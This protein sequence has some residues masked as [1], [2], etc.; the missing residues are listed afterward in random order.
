MTEELYPVLTAGLSVT[1]AR[2]TFH[3]SSER[4][5]PEALALAAPAPARLSRRLLGALD[6]G[7]P[8]TALLGVLPAVMAT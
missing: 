5:K 2:W 8:A 1:T 3:C 6:D 7:V 4:S